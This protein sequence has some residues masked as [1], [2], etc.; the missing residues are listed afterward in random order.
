MTSKK[1]T[2]S[3][4]ELTGILES[5]TDLKELADMIAERIYF[6]QELSEK[7]KIAEFKQ[8]LV[9]FINEPN[10]KRVPRKTRLGNAASRLYLKI[11]TFN[12]NNVID[13]LENALIEPPVALVKGFE[14]IEKV[15][16]D[17]NSQIATNLKHLTD[18]ELDRLVDTLYV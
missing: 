8:E 1:K 2:I 16:D 5:T 10:K 15:I 4:K 17:F 9:D 3:T 6:K 7:Q 12:N 18:E 13:I 11:D 14:K